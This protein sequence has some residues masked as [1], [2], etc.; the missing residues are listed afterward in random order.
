MVYFM[1]DWHI[2]YHQIYLGAMVLRSD[3][4]RPRYGGYYYETISTPD[5]P[6]VYAYADVRRR[7]IY[8]NRAAKPG[9]NVFDIARCCCIDD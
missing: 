8:I 3:K 2:I 6:H 4:S 1:P 5:Q 9:A 7:I